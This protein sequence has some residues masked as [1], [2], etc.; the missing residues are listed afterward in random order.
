[1]AGFL[2]PDLWSGDKVSALKFLESTLKSHKIREA[3]ALLEG[4]KHDYDYLQEADP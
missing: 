3:K 4:A 2:L 1:L